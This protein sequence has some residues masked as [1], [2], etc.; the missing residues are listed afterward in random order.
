MFLA[1]LGEPHQRERERERRERERERG[2]KRERERGGEG[3]RTGWNQRRLNVQDVH[4]VNCGA[5][6]WL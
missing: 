6:V 1:T 3:C 4:D 5:A 2:V